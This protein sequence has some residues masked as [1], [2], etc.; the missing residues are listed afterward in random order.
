MRNYKLFATGFIACLNL[1]FIGTVRSQDNLCKTA[2][3]FT[4]PDDAV[5]VTPSGGA[6]LSDLYSTAG[7]TWEAWFY[8]RGAIQNRTLIIGTEDAVPFEDIFLG[9]GWG[10]SANFLSFSVSPNGASPFVST[11]ETSVVPAINRWQHVAAVCD[12]PNGQIRL[13]LNGALVAQAPLNMIVMSVPLTNNRTTIIGNAS[14]RTSAGTM[15]IDE[16]RFWSVART[17]AEIQASYNTCLSPPYTNL[18]AYFK[19]NENTGTIANSAVNNNFTG[20]FENGVGWTAGVPSVECQT[21]A[22]TTSL[23]A[24]CRGVDFTGTTNVTAFP[25]TWSWDFGDMFTGTGQNTSH[26]YASLGNYPATATITDAQGCTESVGQTVAVTPLTTTVTENRTICQGQDY[27]GY[28]TSGTYTNTATGP[29]GC[30]IQTILNLTVNPKPDIGP[31]LTV[32]ICA[33]STTSLNALYN[34][35]GY[36]AIWNTPDPGAAPPGMYM[37]EVIDG[38]NCRD[39]AN[40][41]ISALP[42][43][44]TSEAVSICQGESYQGYSSSGTYVDNFT[45]AS[46]CDSTRTLVLTVLGEISTTIDSV[47]CPGTNVY[48]YTTDGVYT[49]VFTSV[50]G[51]DST[52]TLTLSF[53]PR[54]QPDLGPDLTLCEGDSIILQGGSF[55]SYLWQDG[56]TQPIFIVRAGGLYRLTVADICGTISDEVNVQSIA[57]KIY[58]PSAFSP[59]GDGLNDQFKALSLGGLQ[60][61]HLSVFDRFGNKVF[62]S[63]D[64][65]NGWDGTVS[66]KNQNSG[67]YVWY[68]E[69]RQNGTSTRQLLKG[70]VM[71]IR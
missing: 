67:V 49:D 41:T 54:L 4:S 39:S 58:F 13:Y 57:C 17:T 66:G 61:F 35:T 68:C 16:V 25:V 60:R 71:L 56:S 7:F 32:P 47:A 2:F 31:D 5:L 53:R 1:L 59:N 22:F 46:G 18:V 28:T 42:L 55:P 14:V 51:C 20:T 24:A 21:V 43:I 48:G 65:R 69:F 70:T 52:R 44:S 62:E 6:Q 63:F 3:R 9:F 11:I 64:S 30:T 45:T 10:P 15:D 26:T 33:N 37:L 50:G 29:D 34:T 19:A 36:T 12:Y 23:N 27:S 40:V 38:N 8:I